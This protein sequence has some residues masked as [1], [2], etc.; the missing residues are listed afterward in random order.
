MIAE[1][2]EDAL[3]K[4]TRDKSKLLEELR[5]QAEEV[6]QRKERDR[7][8]ELL[9]DKVFLEN[10]LKSEEAARSTEKAERYV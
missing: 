7:D 8:A 1:E 5:D 10:L 6:A 4:I 9:A 2:R 3:R